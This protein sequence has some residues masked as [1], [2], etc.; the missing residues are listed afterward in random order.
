MPDRSVGPTT[1]GPTTACMW[2]REARRKPLSGDHSG[3]ERSV[4]GAWWLESRSATRTSEGSSFAKFKWTCKVV[5]PDK[6]PREYCEPSQKLLDAAMKG[7]LRSIE[8][9]V[10]DQ[11]PIIN[12]RT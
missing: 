12:V 5:D 4:Q 11:E 9:C 1:V 7:G 10:I 3:A 8:G 2:R 6:V